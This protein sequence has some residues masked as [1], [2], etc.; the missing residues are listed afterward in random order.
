MTLRQF[1][2]DKVVTLR[3]VL[4]ALEHYRS[5]SD[6]GDHEVDFG[7]AGYHTIPCPGAPFDAAGVVQE[8]SNGAE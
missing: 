7:E 5:D 3:Q 1:E 6:F 8:L 2:L 4:N